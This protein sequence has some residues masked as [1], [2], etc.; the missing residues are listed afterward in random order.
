MELQKIEGNCNL[1][2]LKYNDHAMIHDIFEESLKNL[3]IIPGCRYIMLVTNYY[4]KKN[5]FNIRSYNYWFYRNI[6]KTYEKYGFKKIGNYK[7]N[8][9]IMVAN[10][11]DIKKALNA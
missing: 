8:T 5:I 6:T 3:R 11:N 2:S 4:R 10:V 1:Y 7:N 9:T